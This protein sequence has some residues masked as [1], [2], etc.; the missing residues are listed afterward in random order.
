MHIYGLFGR[1]IFREVSPPTDVLQRYVEDCFILFRNNQECENMFSKFNT[2]YKAISFTVD[3][4]DDDN[5]LAFLDVLVKRKQSKFITSI[6]RKKTFTGQYVNFRS[7]CSLKRKT[8]L[9]RTLYERANKICSPETFDQELKRISQILQDNSYPQD[10]IR[11]IFEQ[12]KINR[13]RKPE[14]GPERCH[15]PIK[16]QFL[17]KE[18]RSIEQKLNL[19]VKNCY[20]SVT[21]RIIFSSRPILNHCHK[22]PIP[23]YDQTM[24]VYRYQCCCDSS[25]VGRTGRRL[26]VR[27]KEHVPKCVRVFVEDPKEP[28]DKNITLVR[29]AKKSSIAQH[30]LE[31]SSCG[32]SF[33]WSRF[34]VIRK[35]K[36]MG[37][38]KI[39]EAVTI[40]S[41]QPNLNRQ[42]EFDFTTTLI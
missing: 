8:N 33:D 40:T 32:K 29:A 38:L 20:F 27:M 1:T 35:C 41:L 15:I 2:L 10:L 9:I 18:S 5:T 42:N 34:D 14:F 28:F 19:A 13:E 4:E 6:F 11:K 37:E 31:S 25:Y 12:Q 26:M 36:H 16:L 17:G 24:V 3:P 23:K 22:D 7:H 30:L 21:P 39:M